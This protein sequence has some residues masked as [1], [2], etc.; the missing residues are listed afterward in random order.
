VSFVHEDP[1]FDGLVR[2]A[3]D[4]R[5]ISSSLVEKDYWVTHTL[6]SLLESGF[7]VWLKGGTSLSKGFSLID[8]FSEDLDL[9]IE[10]GRVARVP[11]VA[12]WKSESKSA[13]ST[14]KAYFTALA[15]K[16]SVPGAEVLLDL[17]SADRS[18][19]TADFRVLFPQRHPDDLGGLLRPFVLLE[20]G[21]A[22]VVPL[23]PRDMS[24]F[25]HDE[26]SKLGQL[27]DFD[28]NR[29]KRVRCVH[30]T[31]TLLEKLDALHR[32]VPNERIDPAAFVRHFE[33]AA[34]I[35]LAEASLPPLPRGLDARMLAIEMEA[36]KQIAGLPS[37]SDPAFQIPATPRGNAIR[38][39]SDA[40]APMFWGNR[41]PIDDACST[42]S[43][44]IRRRLE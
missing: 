31:V 28:E 22:R 16:L 33:D 15:S 18:W 1:D 4:K 43:A 40:I 24:S 6:W 13:T 35:V 26:L 12:N 14:R 8:R 9:K 17:E 37:S 21:S 34:K 30:P 38:A 23:V 20:V 29:P 39:A 27:G 11:S 7:E 2:I 36:E 42:I 19:R 3:A 25:I 32:R 41:I 10:G 44:W 5:R